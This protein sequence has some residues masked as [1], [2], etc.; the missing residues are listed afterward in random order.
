[1]FQCFHVFTFQYLLVRHLVLISD[2]DLGGFSVFMFQYLNVSVFQCFN[3][4]TF[5]YFLA[6]FLILTHDPLIHHSLTP[7]SL[8][9]SLPTPSPSAHCAYVLVRAHHRQTLLAPLL[10]NNHVVPVS[11]YNFFYC[12]LVVPF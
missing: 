12:S 4:F 10:V 8:I 2:P 7:A 11:S 5:Q 9:F 3:V 6:H 1:M